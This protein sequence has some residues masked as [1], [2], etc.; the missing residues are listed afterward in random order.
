MSTRRRWLIAANLGLAGA[1][2]VSAL[3]VPAM[4]VQPTTRARGKYSL[5]AGQIQGGGSA[6]AIYIIDSI[7]EEIVAVRW[8]QSRNELDGIDY[9]DLKAD[10]QQ[11]VGR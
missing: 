1:I 3:A 6:S 10:A 7:N 5:V 2:G 8:N 9:R 11:E 4:G